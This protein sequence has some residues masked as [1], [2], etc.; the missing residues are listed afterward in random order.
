MRSTP[1]A[2]RSIAALVALPLVACLQQLST[3]TGTTDPASGGGSTASSSSSTDAPAG[4]ECGTD[5][6]SGVTLCE[7]T[8]LCPGVSVDQGALPGCGFRIHPGN[9]IDLECLCADSLCPI[10]IPETCDQATQ[11]LSSQTSLTVCQQASD[12]RCVQVTGS[13]AGASPTTGSTTTPTTTATPSTCDK[14][15]EGE[16]AGEPNCIQLCGC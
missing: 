5:P 4:A 12:G 2:F 8:S 15:C 9:V 10:G 3:G 14:V 7:Q 11:L 6:Q 16:C 13:D 1:L